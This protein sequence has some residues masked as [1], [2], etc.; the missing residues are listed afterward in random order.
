MFMFNRRR[1][2]GLT[3][4][5]LASPAVFV[6]SAFSHAWPT[7]GVR[8]IVPFTPG[9]A[10]DVSGRVLANALQQMWG[11]PV[12]VENKSGAGGNLG[13]DLAA[14][15]DPD[16][17]TILVTSVG[18]AT[19]KFMYPSLTYDPV[20][21][22]E[23]VSLMLTMP[24]IMC[25]PNNSP[26]RSVAEFVDHC[27]A[28]PDKATFGSSGI[29]ST[30][31]L[32]GELF[33][34]LAGVKMLHV[35][36]RG[37]SPL[38]NDLIP[39]RLD[40]VFDPALSSSSHINGGAVRGLAV[41]TLQRA[42]VAPNL[43]TVDEAGVKGFDVSSWIGVFLPINAPKDIV[44]KLHAD[45]AAAVATDFVRSRLLQLGASPVGSTP[46]ELKSF[47]GGEMEKW[48]RLIKE[49]KISVNN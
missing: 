43:P 39:G 30:L 10:T 29:G 34:K 45:V 14:K 17:Y 31:H 42:A 44:T 47:L 38:M 19:N 41:T 12:V 33:N 24:N 5:A 28:N 48:G 15:A 40:V 2:I 46:N 9:G 16:G 36:Y 1:F 49:A 6:K 25:V 26:A 27:K 18:Q 8:V 20:A 4:P 21:D 3:T 13:T 23:P 22:F 35:P 32:A 11:Q 7:R 37:S